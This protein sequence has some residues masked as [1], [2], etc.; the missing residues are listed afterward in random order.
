MPLDDDSG[1]HRGS[2]ARIKRVLSHL[3]RGGV[4][5]G[6]TLL[7][8]H[9]IGGGTGDELDVTTAAF[10]DQ[11]RQVADQDVVSLDEA[12]DRLESGSSGHSV[13]LTFDDGFEDVHANAWP[14]LK[15]HQL[16]FTIYLAS[17]YVGDTMRWEGSTAAGRP[18]RGVSWAQL[19]E[20]LRSGLCTI[21]NHTHRHVRPE[22]LTPADLDECSAAIEHSLGVRPDHFTYPWGIG[23]PA[24]EDD[25]RARF[26]SASTGELGRNRPGVDPMRLRRVPVRR[27][28]PAPFFA[29]KLSGRLG[30]E[31]AYAG[32]VR[33]AKRVGLSA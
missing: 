29:A 26:R 28:D 4:A 22:V 10:A 23:V 19:D 9:R 12:M 20:M 1:A 33:T 13:V 17:G 3:D 8:Y 24:I 32:I 31:R 27:T 11:M 2:R 7:I 16:P 15:E 18:G 25:L 21:G 5:S 14:I 30:A 6:A